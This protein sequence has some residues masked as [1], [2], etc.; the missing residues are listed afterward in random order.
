MLSEM[1]QKWLKL[2]PYA[3]HLMKNQVSSRTS[4]T[5]IELF[6]GRPGFNFEFP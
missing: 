5:P 6:L 4:F 1:S 2:V 3:I